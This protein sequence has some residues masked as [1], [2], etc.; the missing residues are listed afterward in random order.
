MFANRVFGFAIAGLLMAGLAPARG[1]QVPDPDFDV[2]VARPAYSGDGPRVLLDEA[3]FNVHTLAGSYKAFA[4][5]VTNDGYKMVANRQPFTADT[6]SGAAVLVIANA[7][8]AATRS[9]KPAWR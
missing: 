5:L 3:H 2:S 8:G 7:R 4:D 9:E 6:L 1:Q